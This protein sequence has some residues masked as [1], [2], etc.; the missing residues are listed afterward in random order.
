MFASAVT[1][2][3]AVNR[4]KRQP[5]MI[6]QLIAFAVLGLSAPATEITINATEGEIVA[7][8]RTFRVTVKSDTPVLQVEFYV[9]EDLREND[10]STPY[11]FKVDT[12]GFDDGDLRLGFVAH[13][14]EGN[15]V[16]KNL[17]VSVDNGL[18]KGADFHVDRA[19]DLVSNSKWDDAIQAAR[20]AL[21]VKSGYAPARMAMARAY[22]GKGVL[23]SAQRYVEDV[24]AATPDNAEALELHSV[25]LL[26]QAFN[27]Y[28]R[29]GDRNQTIGVIQRAL[30]AAVESRRKN[31][32]AGLERMLPITDANRVRYSDEAIKAGRYSAA[33]GALAPALRADNRDNALANRVAYAQIRAGRF[34]DAK[35]TLGD[36]VKFGALDAYGYALMAVIESHGGSPSGSDDAMREA[37]LS[38]A[39][40]LGVRT[41]QAYIALRR[42]NAPVLARLAADLARDQGGRSEVNFYLTALSH[43]LN[44]YEDSRRFFERAVMSEP[45]NY[46]MYIERAN[47]SMTIAESST[48]PAT[49]KELELRMARVLFETALECKGDSYE[50]LTG[51]A[52]VSL[53][54]GRTDEAVRMARA[55]TGAGPSYPA[56]HFTLSAALAAAGNASDAAAAVTR[57]GKLDVP[58]LDGRGVPTTDMAWRYFT[59][60]GRTPLLAAPK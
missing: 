37:I 9:G 42:N 26:Q 5:N 51:L 43:K 33:I 47:E 14:Q 29:G 39:E 36:V 15:P 23:D 10:T 12:L 18:S 44:R 56:G 25:V 16:R 4:W 30:K 34:A 13:T 19:R 52:L 11:E 22:F 40:D 8:E 27:T 7:G 57:A 1:G 53:R 17:R 24:L 35:T 60:L 54:Q 3:L 58:N 45:T 38:D 6:A 20:I 55:A 49:D 50:A 31:L 48:L 46:D 59:Q 32:D 21:K 2:I 28:N 41:A